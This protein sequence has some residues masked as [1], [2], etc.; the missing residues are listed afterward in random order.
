MATKSRFR[1]LRD[2]PGFNRFSN[3]CLSVRAASDYQ[4]RQQLRVRASIAMRGMTELL[5]QSAKSQPG[6]ARLFGLS[7]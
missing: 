6:L 2:I 5:H 7:R 3:N 4:T 1:K